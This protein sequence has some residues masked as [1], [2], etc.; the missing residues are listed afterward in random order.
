MSHS[1]RLHRIA[2]STAFALAL[3]VG[4]ALV[5]VGVGTIQKEGGA[6]PVAN[7]Q[8]RVQCSTLT[9]VVP[10]EIQE[11][12]SMLDREEG[13]M[14]IVIYGTTDTVITVSITDP[15]CLTDSVIGPIMARHLENARIDQATE[16]ADLAQRVASGK[17]SIRDREL[18]IDKVKAYME[19]WC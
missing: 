2:K 10:A 15:L 18:N 14:T 13:T 3:L 7:A 19:E 11:Y 1:A 12:S 9:G 4:V 16:C 8:E 5:T 17:V 6:I